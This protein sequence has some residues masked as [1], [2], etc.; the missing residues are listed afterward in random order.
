MLFYSIDF[1]PNIGFRDAQY[2]SHLFVA[3]IIQ[4]KQRNRPVNFIEAINFFVEPRQSFVNVSSRFVQDVLHIVQRF[5]LLMFPLL[6]CPLDRDV[7]RYTIYLGGGRR[8]APE[9]RNGMPHL[10]GDLLEEVVL[11]HR[12]C[13][14]NPDDLKDHRFMPGKPIFEDFLLFALRHKSDRFRY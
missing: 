8:L 2:I 1:Y 3:E 4:E 10:N 6:P 13:C 11:I 5:C 14:V 9:R 7:E 12:C